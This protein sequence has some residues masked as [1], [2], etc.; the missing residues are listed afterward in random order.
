[1]HPVEKHLRNS[2]SSGRDERD[3]KRLRARFPD[4][5]S[6][7]GPYY[8]SL[9]RYLDSRPER[10]FDRNAF[11]LTRDWLWSRDSSDHGGLHAYLSAQ[12]S[13]LSLALLYLREINSQTWH[14]KPLS[15]GDEFDF[16]RLIERHIHPSYLRLVEGVFAPLLR[17]VAYFSRL[18]RKKGTDGLNIYSLVEECRRGPMKSLVVSYQH[19]M[20]NG[21]AHGGITYL[22][23]EI[24]YQDSS[25]HAVT[26][27]TRTVVQIFDDLLDTCNGVVAALRLFFAVHRE[28]GFMVPRDLM[29]EELQEETRTPWWSIEGCVTGEIGPRSQLT[30]FARPD[31]RDYPKV[32]WSTI[33]SGLLAEYFAPGFDRYFF[34]L[35]S[36]KAWRGWASFDGNKLRIARDAGSARLEDYCNSLESGLV[37]YV[38]QPVGL[39]RVLGRIDT[40]ITSIR[41]QWPLALEDLR[42]QL[43]LPMILS[44][45]SRAHRN[46]WGSVVNGVVVLQNL[47]P[48]EMVTTVRRHR[49]RILSAAVS[50]ARK[51]LFRAPA[52]YLPIAFGQVAVFRRDYR[53]RRLSN[54]GLG[55]DLVCTVRLQR[56]ARIKCP[57]INGSTVEAI[58]RWRIAWNRAWVEDTGVSLD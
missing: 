38:P 32:Q 37:F 46:S 53:R 28:A 48:E 43:E 1:M 7:P 4:L 13:K 45:N 21:I 8:L 19:T 17:I 2:L 58:G 35:E 26:L 6:A 44:R 41:M 25:G 49:R 15:K 30:V 16:I 56:L 18:D 39:P 23:N 51:G 9:R 36:P 20:R 10:F 50:H 22:Q 33:Q 11:Q 5:N 24:R 57:D 27:A 12:D 34:S 31:T 52:A 42:K 14:D 55:S 47:S 40:L 29:I 54:F 3:R